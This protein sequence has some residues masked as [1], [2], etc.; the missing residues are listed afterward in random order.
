M[1]ASDRTHDV[2]QYKTAMR[3]LSPYKE[4]N[5]ILRMRFD[6]ALDLFDNNFFDFIYVDGYAHTGEDDGQTFRDWFPKLK[7]GGIFAGDDYDPGWPLV[8]EEV[9]KFVA[10]NDL[11]LHTINCRENS[12]PYSR[13]PSWLAIKK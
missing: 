7:T 1:W 12:D 9:D 8:V 10:Q 13:S 4:K 2:E 6:E 5:S 3:N 11:T